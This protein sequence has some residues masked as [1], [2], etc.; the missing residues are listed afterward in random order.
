MELFTTSLFF[1]STLFFTICGVGS[2]ENK[3]FE[4]NWPSLDSRVAP[5]WYDDSKFGIFIHWGV[6]S[7]PSFGDEWFWEYWQGKHVKKYVD[8]MKNNYPPRFTYADFAPQFT[9]EFFNPD[10]WTQL[11][12]DAGAKY[13]VFTTK[14]H[15][16]YA[17]WPSKGNIKLF[18]FLLC[19]TSLQLKSDSR[20]RP[21]VQD[22]VQQRNI[23][24]I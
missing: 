3:R 20:L 7:V 12:K 10:E 2:T 19:Q 21:P 22:G 14:H 5:Q 6:F 4:P 18:L 13:I 15:E 23:I 11:F 24:F 8:F 9:A 1:L 16:G 17:N